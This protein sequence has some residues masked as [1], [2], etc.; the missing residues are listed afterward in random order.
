M[1]K[2]KSNGFIFDL[3]GTI[4]LGDKPIPG[5]DKVLEQLRENGGKIRFVT[6]NPRFG[7]ES[8]AE[9]LNNMG[10]KANV[11]EIMTSARLTADYL[12][13]NPSYGKVY[14][15]G[16][17]QLKSELLNAG[18][19]LVDSDKPDTVLIS[20][21]TTLSYEKL[22]KA[23]HGLNNGARFIATNPDPVCPTPDGGLVDAG[24]IIAALEAATQRKVE[25][26]IG[27]PS[28]LLAQLLVED[29]DMTPEECVV[30][31]DRLNTDVRLGKQAG[32]KT[33]W[34]RAHNEKAPSDE[35]RQPDYIVKSIA[36]LPS[37]MS[38]QLT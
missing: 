23:F 1:M 29:L 14:M 10:I 13:K 25:K 3:D 38:G 33:V 31:G 11:D 19:E 24:A 4:Y 22:L 21:D 8:Y 28:P 7:R 35:E 32:M 15:V 17:E 27:K 9:K 18:V 5:A 12:E 2:E 37:V 26:V 20:F 30:V 16:E 36:E 34:I 6:N